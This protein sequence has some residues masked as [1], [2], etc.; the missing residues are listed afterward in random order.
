MGGLFRI[1]QS[2]LAPEILAMCNGDFSEGNVFYRIKEY[3]EAKVD[4]VS[5]DITDGPN[6]QYVWVDDN[7]FD[8]LLL[9]SMKSKIDSQERT[10]VTKY[11]AGEHI[12]LTEFYSTKELARLGVNPSA[13]IVIGPDVATETV[14]D[15]EHR[16]GAIFIKANEN[17]TDAKI[18]DSLNHEFR[19]LLQRYNGFATGFTPN[20]KVSHEMIEDVKKHVPG[21]FKNNTIVRWAKALADTKWEEVI[22]QRFVY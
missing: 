21:L 18:I 17:T 9:T 2:Y 15:N 4:G 20:F 19:H 13:Y 1:T 11:K 22:V 7:A 5:I 6:P 12:S 10:L 3:V 16:T 14:F 8:D